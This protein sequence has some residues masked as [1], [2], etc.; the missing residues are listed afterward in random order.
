[1][2]DELYTVPDSVLFRGFAA[3]AA[4]P[5]SLSRSIL[6]LNKGSRPVR[7]LVSPAFTANFRLS[8]PGSESHGNAQIEL[9]LQPGEPY[10]VRR[11]LQAMACMHATLSGPCRS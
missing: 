2:P 1:M 6:L 4:S 5:S 9:T 7:A 11:Q 8:V 10:K 3:L